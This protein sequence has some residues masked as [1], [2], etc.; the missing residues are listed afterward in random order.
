MCIYVVGG[1]ICLCA[2]MLMVVIYVM[3]I[4]VVGD[5]M[6]MCIYV[7]GELLLHAIGGEFW[8]EH[9]LDYVGVNLWNSYEICFVVVES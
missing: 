9:V 8:C 1:Y 4:Y 5:Y 6:C 3:C 7:V 2:Y